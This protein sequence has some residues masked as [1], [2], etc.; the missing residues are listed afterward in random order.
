MVAVVV[1][2]DGGEVTLGEL[3]A[4]AKERLPAYAAPRAVELVSRIPL[5]PNGKPDMVEL[6]NRNR[7]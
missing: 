6:K 1:P 3:R 4:F 7:G 2:R 5:L